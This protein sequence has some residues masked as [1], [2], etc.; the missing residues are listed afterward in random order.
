MTTRTTRAAS[1]RFE[2]VP[3]VP[4]LRDAIHAFNARLDAG[5][6][7]PEYR[8]TPS[9]GPIYIQH[10]QFGIV[11]ERTFVV[12]GDVVRGG[13]HLQVQPF[14]IDGRVQIVANI[15]LPL[16]E[17]IVDRK[18][19]FLGMWILKQVVQR[20][21]RCFALGMGG[22]DRPLPLLLRAMQWAVWPVPFYF[23]LANPGRSVRELRALGPLW[24]RRLAGTALTATGASALGGL[25]WGAAAAL[26]TRGTPRLTAHRV[27]EW[28]PWTDEV[29]MRARDQYS[30]AALRDATTLRA[31]YPADDAHVQSY[32]LRDRGR[33]VG[34]VALAVKQM[35]AN[36]HFGNLKVGTVLDALTEPGYEQAAVLA[37][38]RLLLD[39]DVDVI[40]TNQSHPTWRS[41]FTR[42][43]YLG[44]S[45]NYALAPSPLLVPPTAEIAGLP[46]QFTRGDGDGRIHL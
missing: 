18:F 32:E 30:I 33:P 19:A 4:D 13:V 3:Y 35:V 31:L 16:S 6:A 25:A 10:Q 45:S 20:Y 28:A 11:E 46:L 15:Q 37:A 17:G 36:K 39:Q 1:K 44:A 21:P 26:R 8:L 29:W 43:L 23:R 22:V 40:V 41:A 12:E 38:T 42:A 5:G 2:L 34:W 7:P 27:T 24:R 9:A 14:W